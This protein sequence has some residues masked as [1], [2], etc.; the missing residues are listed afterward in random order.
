MQDD[1]LFDDENEKQRGFGVDNLCD[2]DPRLRFKWEWPS[3]FKHISGKKYESKQSKKPQQVSKAKLQNGWELE[4]IFWHLD[5]EAR[6][7]RYGESVDHFGCFASRKEV[8][9]MKKRG[10]ALLTRL[11]AQL[12]AEELF[13]E[14]ERDILK[15]CGV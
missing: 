2:D 7:N 1:F 3:T 4:A 5:Y 8:G 14:L 9:K 15:Q 13:K 6:V 11:D 12:K 10:L